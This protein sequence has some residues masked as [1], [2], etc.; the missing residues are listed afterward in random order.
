[1]LRK[2][3][4]LS[5]WANKYD[6]PSLAYVFILFIKIKLLDCKYVVLLDRRHERFYDFSP[7]VT[8][9]F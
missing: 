1:M 5:F 8:T 7:S 6:Q 9:Q 3:L 4:I 2:L